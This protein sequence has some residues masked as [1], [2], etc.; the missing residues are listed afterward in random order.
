MCSGAVSAE[1]PA[2][3]LGR[4]LVPS[5]QHQ[6]LPLGDEQALAFDHERPQ[7]G[8]PPIGLSVKC[9][10]FAEGAAALEGGGPVS[11]AFEQPAESEQGF[12]GERILRFGLRTLQG[13]PEMDERP[14]VL[15]LRCGNRTE[16]ELHFQVVGGGLGRQT[17]VLKCLS[18]VGNPRVSQAHRPADP[19]VVRR[20]TCRPFQQGCGFGKV[21]LGDAFFG[22]LDGGLGSL[23]D[24]IDAGRV[25]RFGDLGCKVIQFHQGLCRQRLKRE[26][27]GGA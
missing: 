26:R 4:F 12:G 9:D 25:H 10:P 19:W 8:S 23:R 3:L 15:L 22:L 6:Q 18:A 14:G 1:G 24:L 17:Q 27:C 5:Q 20:V 11:L 13:R 16:Q 2:E 7:Q 21:P